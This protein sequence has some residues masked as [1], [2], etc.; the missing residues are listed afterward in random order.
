MFC[1]KIGIRYRKKPR[2]R[3]PVATIKRFFNNKSTTSSHNR[4]P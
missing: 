1:A 3:K 2:M 4:I